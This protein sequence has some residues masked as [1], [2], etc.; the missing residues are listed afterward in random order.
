MENIFYSIIVTIKLSDDNLGT[1][2]ELQIRHNIE[3]NLNDELFLLNNGYCDGG[4]TGTGEM[5]LFIEEVIDINKALK[6]VI[7]IIRNL[8][9][10]TQYKISWR[11]G[12]EESQ[13]AFST[14]E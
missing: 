5:S 1:D 6:T 4:D 13:V 12:A 2:E 8:K 14:Y 11:K 3:D 7:N 9:L 10:K